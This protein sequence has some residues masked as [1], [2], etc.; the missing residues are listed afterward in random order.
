M[1]TGEV[2]VTPALYPTV[3]RH[4]RVRPLLHEFRYRHPMWL[5]DLDAM[6]SSWLLGGVLSFE[7][8]DHIGSPDASIRQNIVDWVAARGL[9]VTGDRILMLTNART[10]GYVFNPLTVFWCLPRSDDPADAQV[11]CV[12]AEVHNTYGGKHAYVVQPEA[13]VDKEFY[14]SPF[15]P[16][17]GSYQMR[18]TLPAEK[19]SVSIALRREGAVVFGANLTGRRK[20]ATTAVVVRALLRHPMA[21]L[22]VSALI[23]YQGVRLFLRGLPVVRRPA[24]TSPATSASISTPPIGA[25]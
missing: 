6:P 9:D 8:R 12:V 20:P 11:D 24:A 4:A 3:I 7:A 13:E 23:R 21:A 1:V 2:L 18:F 22:R 19:V 15:N 16:V 14:V 5:V 25:R 17:D 10:F